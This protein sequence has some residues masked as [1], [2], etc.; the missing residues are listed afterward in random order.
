MKV[1][2]L[3]PRF[4]QSEIPPLIYLQLIGCSLP[5]DVE[6][7]EGG[8]GVSALKGAYVCAQELVSSAL[9]HFFSLSWGSRVKTD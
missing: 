7:R 8:G 1:L 6:D 5:E 2:E 3:I 4:D 9:H